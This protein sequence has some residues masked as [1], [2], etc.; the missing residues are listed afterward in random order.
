MSYL[1]RTLEKVIEEASSRFKVVM[2]SGMRQVGK[3]TLL[4]HKAAPDRRL[5]TLDNTSR[6]MTARS[7]PELFLQQFPAPALIDEIQLAPELFRPLKAAVDGSEAKGQYWITGSQRFSLMNQ[8][9]DSLPGR[10]IAFELMPLS[11]YERDGLGALQQPYLPSSGCLAESRLKWR[12]PDET[13]KV[14]WQGAWPEVIHDDSM[15]REWFFN[16]LMD[17]YISRDI[18]QLA[19]VSKTLE[20][21]RFL[22]ALAFLSGRELRLNTLAEMSGVDTVT[23]RR[24]LSIAEASGLIY[25]L[26]PFERN[27]GK[28]LVKSPRL[29][30]A[31]TGLMAVLLNIQTPEEMRRHAMA[32]HFYETFVVMEI[33]KSWVHNGKVPDIC[34]LRESRGMEVDLLIHQEGKYFPVEIKTGLRPALSDAKWILKLESLGIP[35][36]MASVISMADE[37][38]AISPGIIVHSIW[39]M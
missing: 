18:A 15:K 19:N 22:T 4:Q 31:D 7:A 12:N 5:V 30:M 2:V 3:S 36:G 10:L 35:V 26:K 9:T 37:P 28:Q 13:W 23:V 20:F 21:R 25:L 8:V 11:L 38:Y 17:L 14:I 39:N 34:F 27:I 33:V 1:P 6:L 24:W 32:G 29:Y 16:S